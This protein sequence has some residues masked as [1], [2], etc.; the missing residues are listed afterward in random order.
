MEKES[1]KN[2]F[3]NATKWSVIT[4]IVAKLISP[5][6]NMIL[7]RIVA[8][9]AF[10]V[11]ATITMIISFVDMFTDAGFQKYLIQHEFKDEN[12]KFKNAN[13]AFWT[14]LGISIFLWI[15]II[16]FRENIAILVGNPGLGNVIAIACIQLL[17][18]SFSSIQMALY[19]RDFN[20]KI[21][22]SVRMVSIFI[23]FAVTIPLAF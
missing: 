2:K 8:P 15:M 6:T 20:F 18:T 1:I 5:I 3:T 14:N 16:I 9:E 11:V 23:P 10:G 13:V 19:R 21:L 7:A 12:E 22:F 4:E 17:L